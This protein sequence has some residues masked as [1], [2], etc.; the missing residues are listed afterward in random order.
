[1][2]FSLADWSRFEFDDEETGVGVSEC[3]CEKER[4]RDVYM[5]GKS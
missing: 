2:F 3:V 4:A 5:C 1:M